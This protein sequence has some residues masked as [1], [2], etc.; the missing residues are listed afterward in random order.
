[1]IRGLYI[2][3]S[4]AITEAKRVDVIANNIANVNT[5]GYKKDLMLSESFPQVL[6]TKINDGFP[7]KDVL[8]QN[9]GGSGV[10]VEND[11]EMY[12]AATNSGFFN[13]QTPTGID[14][15][16]RIQFM[17][18]ENGD[19]VTP[20][21][22]SILGQNGPINSGGE[23]VTIDANGQVLAGGTVLDTLK[24]SNPINNIGNFSYGI[25][26]S[27]VATSFEQGSVEPTGNNLD[28]AIEG[29]GFFTIEAPQ[30]E[31]YTRNGEFTRSADGY[32]VT[33]EG[34]KVMGDNG[35]I[36]LDGNNITI[37]E[38]GE[39]HSDGDL[40]DKLKLVDFQNYD[41]LQKEGDALLK[42]ADASAPDVQ[43][44]GAVQQGSL[45]SSN[46]NSVK[47][48][49]EMLT[50]LRAYEANQKVIKIH[51]ELLGRSVNDIGKV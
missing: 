18:N 45:E 15:S 29:K 1:M 21:G 41:M 49:V 8:K 38:K 14:R 3:A 39:V 24:V 27:R 5:T 23:P 11:G 32:L 42:T 46:V 31:R 40:V 47:E 7:D 22:N 51:D 35:E 43:F 4:S 13:V 48:M 6:I 30:G 33:A 26:E 28:L 19:L 10:T 44:E 34:Y 37:N 12:S 17:I 25:H 2:A 20:Q 9:S 16:K 50:V 36:K